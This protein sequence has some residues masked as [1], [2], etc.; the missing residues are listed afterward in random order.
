MLGIRK[1]TMSQLIAQNVPWKLL[2]GGFKYFFFHSY[3]G[4]MNPFWQA[5]F[6][7]GLKPPSRLV[8]KN[9]HCFENRW[10]N[11]QKAPRIVFRVM[12]FPPRHGSG[13]RH[14]SFPGG[15]ASPW[16]HRFKFKERVYRGRN[17]AITCPMPTPFL[18]SPLEAVRC[19]SALG[20]RSL[21]ASFVATL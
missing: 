21:R 2:G 16:V 3:L 4:K 13:D 11:S 1:E 5:Y 9:I 10:S 8:S 18:I 14:R 17:T 6:S 19:V 15:I 12:M 7:N 20:C